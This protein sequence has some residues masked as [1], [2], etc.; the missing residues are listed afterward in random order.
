MSSPSP[1][2]QAE[3][4]TIDDEHFF[5]DMPDLLGQVAE[6]LNKVL[7]LGAELDAEEAGES[8]AGRRVCG[9]G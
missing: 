9:G 7:V 6:R 4:N 2:A 8:R 1:R 5:P 3:G